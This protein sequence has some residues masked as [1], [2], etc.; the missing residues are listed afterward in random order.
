LFFTAKDLLPERLRL[1]MDFN[2][3][4]QIARSKLLNAGSGPAS[5]SDLKA[6]LVLKLDRLHP[7][8]RDIQFHYER[9]SFPKI[10]DWGWAD[11]CT[12]G[13]GV[14]IEI[15]WKIAA[16]EGRPVRFESHKTECCI[17]GID[18][19]I[20]H[21]A[22]HQLLDRVVSTIFA[23]SLKDRIEREVE[24]SLDQFALKLSQTFN[25]IFSGRIQLIP[26]VISEASAPLFTFGTSQ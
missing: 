14:K 5:S 13:D 16:P 11:V 2:V 19:T 18:V 15:K 23:G 10:E 4:I 20:K 7:K 21:A 3:D 12:K 24:K 1:N 25:D 9:T 6:E 8:L 26:S 17:D 22:H